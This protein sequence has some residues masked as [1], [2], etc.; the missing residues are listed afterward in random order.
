MRPKSMPPVPLILATRPL[1]SSVVA[2]PRILG[3]K[4]LNTVEPA[5]KS[6]TKHSPIL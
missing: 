6:S 2:L 5:A 4:I 1:K 3:P